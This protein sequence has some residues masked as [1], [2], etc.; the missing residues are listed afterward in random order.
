[1]KW[2][3]F[4]LIEC[5]VE[6]PKGVKDKFASIRKLVE[7]LNADRAKI[8]ARYQAT[9]QAALTPKTAEEL[10]SISMA[11]IDAW[12]A[13]LSIRSAYAEWLE[14][15]RLACGKM[16]EQAF[17]AIEK[18]AATVTAKLVEIGYVQCDP[19]MQQPG[20]ITPGMI[21]GHPAHIAARARHADIQG[22]DSVIGSHRRANDT[23]ADL[24][25]QDLTRMRTKLL[26]GV[27]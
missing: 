27:A 8:D 4:S 5:D 17:H 22:L 16:A 9:E 14:S 13:E 18:T 2:E 11:R 1:M 12:Q 7:Q 6:A 25:N 21:L 19:Q 15:Y 3:Q 20:K 24:V 10:R 26:G 23:A